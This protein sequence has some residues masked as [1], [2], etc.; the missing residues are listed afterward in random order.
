MKR[1]F[2]ISLL[3]SLLIVASYRS[4]ASSANRSGAGALSSQARSVKVY[5]VALGDEGKLGRKIGCGDS[6]VAVSRRIK[7]TSAPLKA[8]IEEL[9]SIPKE[10]A[11]DRRLNNFW[12]GNNLKLKSVAIRGGTATIHIVGEGPFLAGVCDHPRIT[13]QIEATARQFRTVKRVRVF[14]NNRSLTSIVR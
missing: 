4:D 7:P 9:L 11:E 8:A 2:S 12:V 6:L 10:Y 5:L 14:V 3:A 1:V 13:S